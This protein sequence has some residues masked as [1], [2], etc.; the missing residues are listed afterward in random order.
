[1]GTNETPV[2]RDLAS[3]GTRTAMTWG[4]GI[5][6]M[7]LTGPLGGWARALGWTVGLVW[8]ASLCLLNFA[9]CRRVHCA[10]TGP[11]FL[12]LAVIAA[13]AGAKVLAFGN[14]AWN[15]LG[16]IALVGGAALTYAPEMSWGR[17]WRVGEREGGSLAR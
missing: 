17:Y 5:L 13:L 3:S 12:S 16:L 9:R 1:M 11:F 15:L 10:F 8:L 7:I 6:L 2:E 4:P 14:N